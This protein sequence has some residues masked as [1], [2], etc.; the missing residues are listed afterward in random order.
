MNAALNDLLDMVAKHR[1]VATMAAKSMPLMVN[2]LGADNGSLLLLSQ[3]RVVHKVLATRETFTQVSEHKVRTALSEGLAGWVLQHRQGGLAS[4]TSLDDRW[5]SMGDT[6]IG[7]A[8][9][10]P[11]LSRNTVIGLLSF[12]HGQRGFLRERHLASAAELAQVLAPLFDVALMAE[13]S[14]AALS[15]LCLCASHP[16]TLLD[17]QGDV[18]VVNKSME[19][20]D[21]IWN[22]GQFAQSLLP[23]ELGVE[24]VAQCDWE[25]MRKLA[26]LPFDANVV[27][28]P[29]VGVWIQLASR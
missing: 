25:G 1:D 6:T 23:R 29:G 4:D 9:V 21:I 13:S 28:F 24:T 16:S 7:S 18:K 3:E 8:L 14:L 15:D 12:H 19:Q 11:M 17:W 20:L 10:V 2:Y 22:P 27:Q 26:T 5:V